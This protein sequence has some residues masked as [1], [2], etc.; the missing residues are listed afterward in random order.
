MRRRRA[1]LDE[2]Q[3]VAIGNAV[4]LHTKLIHRTSNLVELVIP[5]EGSIIRFAQRRFASRNETPLFLRRCGGLVNIGG[6]SGVFHRMI[7]V[8]EHVSKGFQM[9]PA[10]LQSDVYKIFGRAIQMLIHALPTARGISLDLIERRPIGNRIAGKTVAI[11]IN[12]SLKKCIELSISRRHP[13]TLAAD[14]NGIETLEM[15][16]IKN[17]PVPLRNGPMKQELGFKDSEE[18]VAF[19]SCQ[20]ELFQKLGNCKVNHRK[21]ASRNVYSRMPPIGRRT[22][23]T[24]SNFNSRFSIRAAADRFAPKRRLR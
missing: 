12:A 4:A 19:R 3:V 18:A 14:L 10:M 2:A 13:Q 17:D 15:P 16:Q 24:S 23:L 22:K 21:S 20:L 11:W 5:A 9:H 1:C 6:R 7:E 8:V